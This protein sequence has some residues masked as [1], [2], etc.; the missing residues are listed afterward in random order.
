MGVGRWGCGG[1]VLLVRYADAEAASSSLLAASD[2]LRRRGF[3]F[4]ALPDCEC[5]AFI[6]VAKCYNW[7][8]RGT[9]ACNTGVC[10]QRE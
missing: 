5:S 2:W 9:L 8:R 6:Q 7:I 3:P 10:G 4:S 1:Q